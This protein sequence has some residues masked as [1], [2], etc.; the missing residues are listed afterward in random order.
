VKPSKRTLGDD[1]CD[2]AELREELR[3]RGTKP[4]FP[5][6]AIGSN[7]ALIGTA[8]FAISL[9][10]NLAGYCGV[11][12]SWELRPLP[13]FAFDSFR[14]RLLSFSGRRRFYKRPARTGARID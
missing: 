2:S 7:R 5:T 8:H 11:M 13:Q 10:T 1:T 14:E 3:E 9:C 6:A 4:L 12:R